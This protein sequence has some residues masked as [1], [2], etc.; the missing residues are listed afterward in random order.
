[1]DPTFFPTPDD[2]RGW[3]AE[4]H[5]SAAELWVGFYR[6]STGRPSLTWPESVDEALCF[7]WIDGIRKSVDQTA[8]KI[9]FTPRRSGS[10]WSRVNLERVVV[11]IEEGRMA[12]A[13]MVAYEA[14]DPEKSARY[15]YERETAALTKAQLARLKANGDAWAFWQAQP[16]GYRKQVTVWVTSAKREETRERRLDTL[17]GDCANGQRIKQLRRG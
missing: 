4:H 11:L 1:M 3:L 7:G 17:I 14:G 15:A 13:G 8:Y 2:F 16:P 6:K 12:P 10:H 5:E 9:R